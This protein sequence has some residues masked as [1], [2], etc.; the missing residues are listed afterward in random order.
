MLGACKPSTGLFVGQ[1]ARG[2]VSPVHPAG[3]REID[4]SILGQVTMHHP[5]PQ[6]CSHGK[7]GRIEAPL[8]IVVIGSLPPPLGGTAVSL[9]Y[10]VDCLA[11][12]DDVKLRIVNT[13]GIR[14]NLSAAGWKLLRVLVC[15]ARFA[16]QSD[17]ITLHCASTALAHWGLF[18]LLVARLAR[19]PLVVRKFAGLDYM[20]LGPVR[21]RIAH[22][23][24]C[25]SALYLAQT[26]RLV[27]LARSRGV[28][29]VE[30]YPTSRPPADKQTNRCNNSKPCRCFVFVGQVRRGKGIAE[31]VE[32]AERCNEPISVDVYGPL[33]PDVD[34]RV[35]EG[36]KRVHYRGV[37]DPCDVPTTLRQ[38]DMQLL[39]TKFQ[40][41]GYPGIVLESYSAGI[42]VIASAVGGIPE[43]VDETS[44]ILVEPGNADALYEAMQ[45]VI[46]DEQYFAKLKEGA[47][48]KSNLFS[49]EYWA[50]RLVELCR[51]V[52]DR[53][54]RQD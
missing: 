11:R 40:T 19:V 54:R 50:N 8:R 1:R 29:A 34:K 51:Q 16:F 22:F 4:A 25:R 38:Y 27:A 36:S 35:F 3:G 18:V 44:G 17:V 5:E 49:T 42:P 12:R 6:A 20:E 43:I 28:P 53:S 37:L 9:K 33:F 46:H 32:A 47:R 13:S 23:V 31:L 2:L 41:E 26:Q 48:A 21:G 7:T 39:P 10:L 24:V 45:R 30:W 15:T 52:V 14:G